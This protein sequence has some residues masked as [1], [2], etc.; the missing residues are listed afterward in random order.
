MQQSVKLWLRHRWFDP[1]P[2]HLTSSWRS[3]IARHRPKVKV[4]RSSRAEDTT[5]RVSLGGRRVATPPLAGFDS[6]ARLAGRGGCS[7]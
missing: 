1:I 3:R 7:R 2:A 6:R 5:A 4:A